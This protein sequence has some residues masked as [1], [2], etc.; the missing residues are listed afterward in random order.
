MN[1]FIRA[2]YSPANLLYDVDTNDAARASWHGARIPTANRHDDDL[3]FE[4]KN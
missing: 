1:T 2:F 3:Q 4:H